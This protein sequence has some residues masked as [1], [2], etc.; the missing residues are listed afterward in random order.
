M[1]VYTNEPTQFG[2]KLLVLNE[3]VTFDNTG[4]AEVEKELGEKM[5]SYSTMFSEERIKLAEPAKKLSKVDEAEEGMKDLIISELQFKIEKLS[6]M[7]EARKSKYGLL[8]AE[9]KSI[10]DE[11]EKVALDRDKLIEDQANIDN[12]HK[13]EVELLNNKFELSLLEVDELKNTCKELGLEEKDYAKKKTKQ[14]LIDLIL[15]AAE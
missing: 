5:V 6:K 15:K 8:E 12:A 7:D 2:R 11:M 9:N 14:P 1:K 13:K 4:C 10:R 3:E